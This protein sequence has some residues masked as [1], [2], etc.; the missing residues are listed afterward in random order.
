MGDISE[1]FSRSEFE[2]KCGCGQNTVDVGLITILEK[3]RKYFNA[4]VTVNSGNRCEAY[5]DAINGAKNS[6]HKRSRAADITVKGVTPEMVANA[7]EHIIGDSGG[8]GRYNTF[9]H[10]DS[11]GY[12]AR[13]NG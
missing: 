2:C 4:P 8:V 12:K 13:W 1:H 5:N 10:V 3:I 6:Q 11:R 7:A 9:T